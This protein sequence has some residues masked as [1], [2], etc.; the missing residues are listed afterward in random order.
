M[1][2]FSKYIKF[3]VSR[4]LGTLVE[5]VVL[6]VLSGYVFFSYAGKYIAA[7]AISFEIVMFFN[8]IISYYWIWSKDISVKS[9][10]VFFTSLGLFNLSAIFGFAIK[11]GFLLLFASIL[12][13]NVVYCNLLALLISGIVNFLLAEM[14][15]F[16]K[17]RNL[18]VIDGY[19]PVDDRERMLYDRRSNN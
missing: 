19:A 5:T 16:K 6:W 3:L 18:P 4:L 17:R 11:M 12:K 7:P 8:F 14:M 15:V 13:W 2:L 10:K 1:S 9:T